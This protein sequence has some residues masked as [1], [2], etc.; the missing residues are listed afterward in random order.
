MGLED[1]DELE[2]MVKAFAEGSNVEVDDTRN[3]YDYE[4]FLKIRFRLL[5]SADLYT[6]D[7]EYKVW[8][9]RSED[10]RF[11][12][13]LVE[14]AEE[15][16]IVGVVRP[17]EDSSSPVLQMGIGYPASL[18]DH[19][20]ARASDSEIVRN[21]QAD[22]GINVF[23]GLPFGEEPDREGMDM[24]T[25]F[26]VDEDAIADAFTIDE[27]AMEIDPS[28]LDLSGLDFSQMDM[29]SVLR[30]EDLAVN[31]PSL[32]ADDIRALIGSVNVNVTLPMLESLFRELLDSFLEY[33][34][35]DPATDY[36]KLP[37]SLR[38]FMETQTA[39]DI[40]L[41]DIQAI[42]SENSQNLITPEQL[43]AIVQE[44]MSGYPAFLAENGYIGE[45]DPFAHLEEYLR[46]PAVS[47]IVQRNAQALAEQLSGMVIT[48]EQLDKVIRDLMDAY[49]AYAEENAL[50]DPAR[51]QDAF[52]EFMGT[53]Q[54]R[55]IISRGVASAI[56]TSA[57]EAKAAEIFAGYSNAMSQQISAMLSRVIRALSGYI[58]GAITNNLGTLMK[59]MTEN[60]MN[61]FR[62]DGEALAKAFS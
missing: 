55:D 60:F 22:P 48:Q 16:S 37:E 23:T 58:S 40:L 19:L 46:T 61:A 47:E 31:M 36:A 41:Q 9:D 35:A 44:V 17:K 33:S 26:S 14:K 34:S 49:Q 51:F 28:L 7:R 25:L 50:P 18:I 13:S 53:Q 12:N 21:Q 1:P 8:T 52:T 39:R 56:D 62:V 3:Q 32:S 10:A 38:E 42:L 4:D 15:L 27:N 57:L 29:N 24:S 43:I 11:V 45:E 30:P 59:S 5:C 6:Y 54:A 2:K 20:M